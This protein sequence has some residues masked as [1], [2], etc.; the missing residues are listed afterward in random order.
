MVGC[1]VKLAVMCLVLAG[2]DCQDHLTTKLLKQA[3]DSLASPVRDALGN[4]SQK[5]F[6]FC[7]PPLLKRAMEVEIL[8]TS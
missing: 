7:P 8:Q 2:M 6:F 4:N 5:C 1:L 3:A